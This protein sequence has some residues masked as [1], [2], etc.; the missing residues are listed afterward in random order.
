[1]INI[2]TLIAELKKVGGE[3]IFLAIHLSNLQNTVEVAIE[4][5]E[6]ICK[7]LQKLYFDQLVCI[8]GI[9]FPK[10]NK[11]EIIYNFYAITQKLALAIKVSV[12]RG[13]DVLPTVPT[14][15]H[16]WATANWH[17][18]EIYDLL[19]IIFEGHP[20]LRRILLPADW[21]GYPLRKDYVAQEKYH[22]IR[23]ES[24]TKN[25]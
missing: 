10:E 5:L 3:D 18:R 4:K 2:D 24:D 20:D 8:T 9:D 6:F 21:Q 17:E 11:I 25:K 14:L 22:G 15:S 13:Q 7:E 12:P 23:V 1:M 16:L 19:G